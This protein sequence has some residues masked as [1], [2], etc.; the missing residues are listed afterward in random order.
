MKLLFAITILI[1]LVILYLLLYKF[2]MSIL[3]SNKKAFSKKWGSSQ[4]FFYDEKEKN[5]KFYLTS[6]FIGLYILLVV[7]IFSS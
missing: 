6:Y 2:G 4:K 7:L 3:K 1:V 5:Y